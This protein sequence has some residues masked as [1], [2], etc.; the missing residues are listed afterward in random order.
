MVWFRK[1]KYTI[2]SPKKKD[3]P[4][5]LWTKCESCSEIIYNKKLEESCGVCPKCDF[6]FRMGARER[7][8]MLADE[9]SF[10]EYDKNMTSTDPLKF[11]DSKPYPE[12]L[13]EAQKKTG[14][15]EAVVTGEMTIE[16]LPVAAGILDFSFMG[17]SM[18]SVVG[19]KVCRIVENA[20]DKKL[21]LIMVCSSGGARMQEGVLSLMQMSKTSAALALFSEDSL[22]YISVLANP[23]TGGVSASFAFLGDIIIAEP[24]ALIGFAGPRVIKQTIQ[25]ELP[26]GFQTAEF[27]LEHGMIDVIVRRPELKSMLAKLIRLLT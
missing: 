4:D 17:G 22:P 10:Y 21:P 20:M 13:S 19:E 15:K 14:L 18:A 5:G 24:R 6:H 1:P 27:L 26:K 2:L 9:G 12:R 3:M 11:T 8:K 7:I 16:E 23:T 25:Q